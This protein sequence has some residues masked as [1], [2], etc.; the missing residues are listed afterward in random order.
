MDELLKI[1]YRN[2]NS[3][4]KYPF[5]DDSTLVL[6]D[7]LLLSNDV[8]VDM[9]MYHF[10]VDPLFYVSTITTSDTSIVFTFT[11]ETV[12]TSATVALDTLNAES[13]LPEYV[14]VAIVTDAGL[15][16]GTILFAAG[17][18][19][20]LASL[21]AGTITLASD[22]LKVIGDVVIP[23]PPAVVTTLNLKDGTVLSGDVNLYA[24]RGFSFAHEVIDSINVVTLN[25]QGDPLY[26]L[27]VCQGVSPTTHFL[28]TLNGQNPDSLGNMAL[29][30]DNQPVIDPMLRISIVDGAIT[31]DLAA[32]E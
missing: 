1:G 20:I 25:A 29:V 18:L 3:R 8:V 16:V 10:T 11:N 14:S 15:Q 9:L 28:K 32:G 6:T 4:V 30:V 17:P 2:A 31:I 22:S 26:D 23:L 13:P 5:T 7:S 19:L 12:T 27:N 24:S 21:L